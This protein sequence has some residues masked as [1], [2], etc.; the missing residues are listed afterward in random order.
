MSG[1]SKFTQRVGF[2]AAGD[3]GVDRRLLKNA[4]NDWRRDLPTIA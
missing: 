1:S 3:S 4:A 2:F